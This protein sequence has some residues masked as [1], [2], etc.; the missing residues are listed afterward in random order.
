MAQ[1]QTG[2]STRATITLEGG[3]R[4]ADVSQ[5]LKVSLEAKKI[6]WEPLDE[7]ALTVQGEIHSYIYFMRSGSREIEGEGLAIPFTRTVDVPG[8]D[9][10]RVDVEIEELDSDHDFDPVTCDF[11]H[12]IKAIVRV[13][14]I[15]ASGEALSSP[16]PDRNRN[17][18]LSAVSSPSPQ[19]TLPV[20]EPPSDEPRPV[21]P[22]AGA[23]V[24]AGQF[25]EASGETRISQVRTGPSPIPDP[26]EDSVQSAPRSRPPSPTDGEKVIVWKPFPPPIDG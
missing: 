9:L 4:L 24:R 22:A 16:L 26:E 13:Q 25:A 23:G 14:E 11:R 21:D 8:L 6:R 7:R 20:A 3:G 10:S 2:A 19:T 12:R 15:P 5:V 17:E 18:I 1:E